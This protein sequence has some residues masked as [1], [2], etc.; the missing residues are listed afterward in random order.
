MHGGEAKAVYC[1]PIEHYE[2]WTKE[3]GGRELPMAMFGEN[4]TTRGLDEDSVHLG[5]RFLMG[6]AEVIVTQPRLP[7]FKLGVRFQ[8]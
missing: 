5:D 3:L 7:C 1:Y 6:T 2:P 8:S 4:L